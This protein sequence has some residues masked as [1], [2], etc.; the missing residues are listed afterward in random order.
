MKRFQSRRQ[1]PRIPAPA[2]P[3][4]PGLFRPDAEQTE[5][6][7]V[8]CLIALGGIVL[9]WGLF[10]FGMRNISGRILGL[11]AWFFFCVP[12]GFLLLVLGLGVL[13]RVV[14]QKSPDWGRPGNGPGS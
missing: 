3:P 14:F 12:L 7:A 6:E 5:I 4:L 11:P 10:H 8:F 13:V 9:W 2:Y 1:K